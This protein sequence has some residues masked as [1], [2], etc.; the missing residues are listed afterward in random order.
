MSKNITYRPDID[1]LRAVAVVLVILFHA[2]LSLFSGGYVGVDVFF[3]ISGF[4]ITGSISKEISEG[5]F[6][7]KTFYLRRIRRIIPVLVFVMLVVTIPASI[8]FF[9]DDLEK[10]SRTVMHTMLSTNNFYL[11]TNG[12]NYFVENTELIPLLHTWSLSVEEQFY[13]IWPFLL[14]GLYKYFTTSKRFLVIIIFVVVTLLISVYLTKTNTS[15][16][17]FLLPARVFELAIGGGLALLWHKIPVFSILKNSILSV[18]GV[19]L[20]IVPSILLTKESLFPGV[21]ALWPCLGAAL[22]IISGKFDAEKGVIN[23][24][25]SINLIKFIGL[26]SYSLYLWHWPIFV[27]IKYLGY[28]L[29]LVMS[30]LAIGFT[31]LLSYFSWKYVE[32]PFRYKFKYDF[33]KTLKVVLLPCLLI[34]GLIYGIIDAKNGFPGRYPELAEFD[35]KA[36]FPN[37]LRKACFGSYKIGNI[38]ECNLGVTK[39]KL[40]GVLIGDSFG[41]HSAAFID[42]LAKDAGLYFHDTTASGFPLLHDVDN[43]TGIAERDP[44]YGLQRLDFVKK[45]RSVVIASNWERHYDPNSKNYQFVIATLKELIKTGIKIFIIDPLHSTSEM[46]LHKMKLFKTNSTKNL[47]KE[48]VLIPKYK[49]PDSYIIYEIQR[50]FPSVKII[51]FND[52]MCEETFCNYEINGTILYRNG[53]HLNHSG[54][55]LLGKKYIKKLGNPLKE[56]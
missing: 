35:K 14:L 8:I 47:R 45:Y 51:N 49:R 27:F 32:Q 18:V 29:T 43:T 33:K 22:L 46:N 31:F 7:F 13:I 1:G 53:N 30:S 10:F 17:Y 42:V 20:I 34:S 54:A 21:N 48:D 26:L 41:N 55:V 37:K 16:A 15:F 24:I 19:L 5:T 6:S 2:N 50:K 25:L 3:V 39:D 38:S 52:V 12:K 11:Y 40:D 56:L 28:E 44:A 4:L 36:N 23:Q 9:A